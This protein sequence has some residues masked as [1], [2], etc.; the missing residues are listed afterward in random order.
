MFA[1]FGLPTFGGLPI[2][3][4]ATIVSPLSVEGVPHPGCTVDPDAVF[5]HA[6]SAKHSKYH[7][8]VASRRCKLLVLAAGTGGRWHDDCIR[9]VSDLARYRAAS[10]LPALQRSMQLAYQRRW[11]SLLSSALHK[12]IAAALDPSLD[13]AEGSFPIATAIDVWVRDPPAVSALPARGA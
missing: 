11:W 4:D 8:L 7:D 10:E 9:F 1:V 6:I 13:I 2:C 3:A 12:S 5:D